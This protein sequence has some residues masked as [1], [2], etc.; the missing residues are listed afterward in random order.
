MAALEEQAAV[1]VDVINPA[2]TLKQANPPA[3][4]TL[5]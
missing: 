5:W 4:K 2:A 1:A 3:G